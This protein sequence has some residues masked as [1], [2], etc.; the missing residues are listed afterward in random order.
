M[1]VCELNDVIESFNYVI[2]TGHVREWES[3]AAETRVVSH[4]IGPHSTAKENSSS[5][6]CSNRGRAAHQIASHT[7]PTSD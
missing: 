7:I 5:A 4:R 6:F 1:N 2:P 3:W